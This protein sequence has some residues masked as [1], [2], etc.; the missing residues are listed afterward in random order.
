MKISVTLID[1]NSDKPETCSFKFR[2]EHQGLHSTIFIQNPFV[3]SKNEWIALIE[4]IE[5]NKKSSLDFS[6][7]NGLGKIRCDGKRV[8]FVNRSSNN[9]KITTTVSIKLYKTEISKCFRSLLNDE[10][11]MPFWK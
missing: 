10:S 7:C 2:F 8:I 6:E 5:D 1:D 11:I 3:H 4:A 9:M